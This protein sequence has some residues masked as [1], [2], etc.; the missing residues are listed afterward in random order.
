MMKALL[1]HLLRL[2]LTRQENVLRIWYIKILYK[3]IIIK[4]YYM[5]LQFKRIQFMRLFAKYSS[6]NA[7]F[8]FDK[9]CVCI[10]FSVEWLWR[11]ILFRLSVPHKYLPVG[12]QLFNLEKN[13][14][15]HFYEYICEIIMLL[16]RCAKLIQIG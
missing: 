16:D 10:F 9:I 1:R 2:E 12:I 4:F 8:E 5:Y 13:I 15:L 14:F 11:R 3:N 6:Y 7:V